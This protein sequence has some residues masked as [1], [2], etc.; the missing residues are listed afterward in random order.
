M[1]L[2]FTDEI[3]KETISRMRA[4]YAAYGKQNS[5]YDRYGL[6]DARSDA[7]TYIIHEKDSR[8]DEGVTVPLADIWRDELPGI[9]DATVALDR[10]DNGEDWYLAL[11]KDGLVY[12]AE[13]QDI[14]FSLPQSALRIGKD[15]LPEAVRIQNMLMQ[16]ALAGLMADAGILEKLNE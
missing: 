12:E 4:D 7:W 1:R 16:S 3:L 15:G 10:A 2:N 13:V 14:W 6:T 5:E 9:E 8:P 11:W